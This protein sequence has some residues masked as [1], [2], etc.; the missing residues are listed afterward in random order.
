MNLKRNPGMITGDYLYISTLGNF[1]VH[2]GDKLISETSHRAQ[3]S[4]SLFIYL[5][6]NRSRSITPEE[7]L[8]NIWAESDEL[9]N[10]EQ[11]LRTSIYR[12]RQIFNIESPSGTQG[13]MILSSQGRYRW[14]YAQCWLDIEEFERKCL[15]GSQLAYED[16][17][18]AIVFLKEA[19]ILYKGT[20]L[21]GFE[22]ISWIEPYR[23]HFRRLYIESVARLISLL[24]AKRQ[25]AG[26]IRICEKA[27]LLEPFEEGLHLSLMEA[28]LEEGK[29]GL[30]LAHYEY[31]TSLYYREMSVKPSPA[32]R[33]I[34]RRLMLNHESVE[35]DLNIISDQLRE[36]DATDGA[37][38]CDA[39]IFRCLYK[40]EERK[41]RRDGD[42]AFL[43]LF[44]LANPGHNLLEQH[45]LA[46][47]MQHL[48]EL[49]IRNLRQGDVICRWNEAQFLVLLQKMEYE[50]AKMI[51][52]RI[53]QK[54]HDRRKKR[55]FDKV[56]LYA[57]PLSLTPVPNDPDNLQ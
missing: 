24:K 39:D 42:P 6:I 56:F 20:F 36:R 30:A 55:H 34:Y 48:N 17:K 47:P 22:N 54:F 44:T 51:I 32:M 21:S 1:R 2:H 3:R 38:Q 41:M 31:V 11:A 15:L 45:K 28:L 8:R 16:P 52:Q 53:K 25:F 35:R 19:L 27:A 26:I 40:L 37:F 46:T 4:W 33:S 13:M 5:V 57:S 10:P 9:K 49:L 43:V 18:R 50:Q 7:L 12:L 29:N 14:N 23:N